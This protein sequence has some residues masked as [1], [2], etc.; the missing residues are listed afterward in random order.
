[1]SK[2]CT[3]QYI[4]EILQNELY[5]HNKEIL[6]KLCKEYKLNENDIF[7]K[8]LSK[9]LNIIEDKNISIEITR[10]NSPKKQIEENIRC[11][12]RVWNRGQG[13]QCTRAKLKN[14]DFCTQHKEKQKHG[15]IDE[16]VPRE[17]FQKSSNV[18]YKYKK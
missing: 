9:E 11:M 5:E 8:F 16:S 10:K 7:S 3:P 2:F 14:C 13:G 6:R 12:A 1:M 15:R 4:F 17:I 18:L